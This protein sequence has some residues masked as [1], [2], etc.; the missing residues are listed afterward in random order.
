M[1]RPQYPVLKVRR[2]RSPDAQGDTLHRRPSAVKGFSRKIFPSEASRPPRAGPPPSPGG[3]AP[4]GAG[5]TPCPA[6]GPGARASPRNPGNRGPAEGRGPLRRTP[7][8]RIRPLPGRGGSE[9]PRPRG[10]LRDHGGPGPA[11]GP[12]SRFDMGERGLADKR[13]VRGIIQPSADRPRC[14]GTPTTSA[15]RPIPPGPCSGR[16]C[17]GGPRGAGRRRR[18]PAST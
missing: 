1:F 9:G 12:A 6:R 11:L 7:P 5:P 3:A 4:S 10:D 18:P 16:G 17:R 13:R 8:A 2:R 15:R 14:D